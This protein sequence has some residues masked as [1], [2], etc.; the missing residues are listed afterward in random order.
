MGLIKYKK[1]ESDLYTVKEIL[2]LIAEQE[3]YIDD[4]LFISAL[5]N[6]LLNSQIPKDKK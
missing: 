2:T 6:K 4:K 5:R 3:P 1:G